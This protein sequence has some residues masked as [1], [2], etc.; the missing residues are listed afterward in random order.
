MKRL[1]LLIVLGLIVTPLWADPVVDPSRKDARR[2]MSKPLRAL[3]RSGNAG[4]VDVIISFK[5]PVDPADDKR[6]KA[7][8][9][10]TKREFGRLPMRAARV[11]A[12]A[13]EALARN[14]LVGF[15]SR[16][17]PVEALSI[18]SLET[19]NTDDLDDPI[20]FNYA[21]WGLCV[22]V[23]DSG[24]GNHTDL[25]P[26]PVQ[27]DFVGQPSAPTTGLWDGWGHGAHVAGVIAGDGYA[28]GAAYRG[29]APYSDIIYNI[30]VAN[31]FP[32]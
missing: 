30:Q 9:V 13:L 1:A 19:A 14:P 25:W 4:S 29:L 24:V 22:A 12:R 20:N 6:I 21:G 10:E 17:A 31:L 26:S 11:P 27:Y 32:G 28:S 2:T 16:D 3:A 15:I 18:S 7:L 23:L 8:G 5:A